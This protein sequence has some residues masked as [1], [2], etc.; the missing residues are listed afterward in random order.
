MSLCH[1]LF[2][3]PPGK[4]ICARGRNYKKHRLLR[5]DGR[6]GGVAVTASGLELLGYGR[7]AGLSIGLI[8]AAATFGTPA[9]HIG[10]GIIA[11]VA[12][13]I[14]VPLIISG[15]DAVSLALSLAGS[16][17]LTLPAAPALATLASAAPLRQN[18]YRPNHD[19]SQSQNYSDCQPLSL[20]HFTLLGVM[21]D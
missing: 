3:S 8:V 9:P 17:P 14:L 1:S 4:S 6:G 13:A 12:L 5:G 20:S 2:F 7:R 19:H 10:L 16:H 21:P 15:A 11:P 18:G